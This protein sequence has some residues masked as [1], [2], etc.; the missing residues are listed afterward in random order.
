MSCVCVCDSYN[1]K[2]Y[3]IDDIDWNRSPNSTFTK[4]S[5]KTEI[6]FSDYYKQVTLLPHR[7]Y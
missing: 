7:L 3:R 6:T 5:D 1:N 2:T 4:S